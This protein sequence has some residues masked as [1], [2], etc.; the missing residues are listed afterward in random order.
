MKRKKL[1][2]SDLKV[3]SFITSFDVEE[4][5]TIK[6]GVENNRSVNLQACEASTACTAKD[7]RSIDICT[8][9]PALC[10]NITLD[11]LIACTGQGQICTGF[12]C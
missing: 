4:Q 11:R 2:L 5:N 9:I 10:V 12:A 8:G 3:Q 7:R 1:K 6:G